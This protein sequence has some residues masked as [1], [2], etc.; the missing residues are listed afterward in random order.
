MLYAGRIKILNTKEA[1]Q[2]SIYRKEEILRLVD[3]YFTKF[4]LYSIKSARLNLI[5]EYYLLN[6]YQKLD[7]TKIEKFNQWIQFK[8]KW[9]R[10]Q[11]KIDY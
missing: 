9:A 6:N 7:V 4:P 8:K 3:N 2:Y 1:F 10:Y 5:K 11:E